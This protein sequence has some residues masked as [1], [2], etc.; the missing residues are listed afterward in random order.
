MNSFQK[1]LQWLVVS[2]ADPGK[3]SLMIK[4]V[5]YGILP[6]IVALAGLAHVTIPENETLT[7]A[8][9]GLALTIQY[10]LGAIA[11][12]LAAYGAIRKIGT[13][14]NGTNA[15]IMMQKENEE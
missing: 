14:L 5:L 3:V 12:I 1:F 8:I 10:G 15:V 2:S 7:G 9:D 6:T 13:T 11:S 4:G